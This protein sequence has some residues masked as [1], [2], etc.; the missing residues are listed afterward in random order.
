MP[1]FELLFLFCLLVAGGAL[2]TAVFSPA[3]RRR[4][5]RRV[6]ICCAVYILIVMVVSRFF[7]PHQEYRVGDQQCFDEWCITV[8]NSKRTLLDS[9]M[10]YDLQLL[11]TS[12]SRGRPQGEKGTVVYLTDSRGRRYNPIASSVPF[13]T[14]IQAG[15]SVTALRRFELPLDAKNVG[16]IY[17][18]IGAAWSPIIG[19]NEWFSGP[20]VV[21]LE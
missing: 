6:G 11:L 10:I 21:W 3:R 5:L 1:I 14:K 19:E 7:S 16:M 9:K 12:H 18:H 13:D 17:E 15:Q 8:V 4:I 2:L 20:P